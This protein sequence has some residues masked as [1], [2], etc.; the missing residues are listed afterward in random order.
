ME[1][2]FP[3]ISLLLG[4]L[5]F[6]LMA[7]K[8]RKST[9]STLP[10]GPRI[11]PIIGN[12]HVLLNSSLLHH[13]LRDL[14][15]EYGPL[16]HLKLGEV[17]HM[18]ISSSEVAQQVMKT[19][20]LN[21]CHR[22]RN[23]AAVII[24]Y[25]C[26]DIV[27]GPYGDQWR[28]LKRICTTELL[29]AKRVQSFQQTREDLVS[30]LIKSISSK[31][32]SLINLSKMIVFLV[33]QIVSRVAFGME[34]EDMELFI[35]ISE[36]IVEVMSGLNLGEFFPSVKLLQSIGGMSSELKN[37]HQRIDN[38]LQNIIDQH[39]ARKSTGDRAVEDENI[40]I[41][42]VLLNLREHGNLEFPLTMDNIK[43]VILDIFIAGTETS[44]TT[45]EWA[46]SELLRNPRVMKKAQGEETFR[47]H[48]P[49]P[50]LVPRECIERCE[51]NGFEIPV[52]SK[53]IIN[54][55]A[56]G[57][58]PRNWKEPERFWPERFNDSPI[59]FKGTDFALLP[60]GAGRRMCPGIPFA[61]ANVELPLAQLLYHFDWKFPSG[62]NHENFDMTEKF[63]AAVRRKTDL[64]LN[65]VAYRSLTV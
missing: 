57:R 59:D 33:P 50:L 49:A 28:Q 12:M 1:F 20:D 16:M 4:F 22:P 25:D 6:V 56:I 36:K 34:C 46:M 26:A 3:S 35:S 65:P 19:H 9:S 63:G 8:I 51:I 5:L 53:I 60:F 43:S 42:D 55:W 32:G 48:P 18:V 30:D 11:L 44:S 17:S 61:L 62:I 52:K 41:V 38:M 27:Y 14:A 45:I 21:F 31:E 2:H 13:R 7:L 58:D 64:Y 23:I 39:I 40:D 37:L 10:P 15:A 47:L 54:A 24:T 29:S